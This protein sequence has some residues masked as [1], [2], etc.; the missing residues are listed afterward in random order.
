MRMLIKLLVFEPADRPRSIGDLG[1][2]RPGLHVRV[3]L[4]ISDTFGFSPSA[5]H[6]LHVLRRHSD[7]L[8]EKGHGAIN[9]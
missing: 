5:D 8:R 9:G 1:E 4:V 3:H 7:F 6:Q 2:I